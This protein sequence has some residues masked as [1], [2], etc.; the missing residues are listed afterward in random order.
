MILHQ[1]WVEGY[2]FWEAALRLIEA[3]MPKLLEAKLQQW[4]DKYFSGF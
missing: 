4:L 1:K 3:E 2:H